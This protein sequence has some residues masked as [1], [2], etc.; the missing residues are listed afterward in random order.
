MQI[1]SLGGGVGVIS[2][3]IWGKGR[4]RHNSIGRGGREVRH[5]SIG[6]GGGG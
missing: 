5:N 6:R 3:L 1:N 4:V 2:N